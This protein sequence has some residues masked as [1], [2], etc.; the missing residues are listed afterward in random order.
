[1]SRIGNK[2]I[3][4]P[5]GVQ[6]RLEGREV[7]VSGPRGELGLSLPPIVSVEMEDNLVRVKRGAE[8]KRAKSL[9]GLHARL[10]NNMM[11]GVSRGF[12]KKLEIVGVGYRAEMD[13]SDLVL[14]LGF[15]HPIRYRP[16]EG[17]TISLE[18]RLGITVSGCDRQKVGET[19]A[20]IRRFRPPEPYKGKGIKYQ[21]EYIKR[22]AGKA[23]A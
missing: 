22:K 14:Q 11:I 17:V 20:Q 15:S 18:G 16:M 6:V 4:I 7:S 2:P 3:S 5:E 8:T 1:M 13:R 23:I 9:H 19:A 21:G 10:I 12:E